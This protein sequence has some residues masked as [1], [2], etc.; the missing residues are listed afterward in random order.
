LTS[1]DNYVINGYDHMEKGGQS[2][3]TRVHLD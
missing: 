2:I 1:D 3:A